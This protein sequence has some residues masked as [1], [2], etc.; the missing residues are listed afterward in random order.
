MAGKLVTVGDDYCVKV[1]HAE[2]MEQVNEFVSENDLPIRVVSQNQGLLGEG[3]SSED[4]DTLVA[5]GFKS[6][7]LRILDLSEMKIIHETLLF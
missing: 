3:I 4:T 7:F 6:G 1:W 2:T 5:I